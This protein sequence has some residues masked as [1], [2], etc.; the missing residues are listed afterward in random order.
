[1]QKAFKN[2][3]LKRQEKFKERNTLEDLDIG[4]RILLK[5]NEE[6]STEESR[7]NLSGS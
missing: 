1:M 2:G 5:T 6:K 4:E 3:E 7:H